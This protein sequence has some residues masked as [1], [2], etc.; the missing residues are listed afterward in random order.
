MI[1][2]KE[3]LVVGYDGSE[4]P[5]GGYVANGQ[6]SPNDFAPAFDTAD[7]DVPRFTGHCR[8]SHGVQALPGDC[9]LC[10]PEVLTTLS[11]C[12]HGGSST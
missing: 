3:G 1:G 11:N 6:V 12:P 10:N 5:E 8:P 4:E 2:W 9:A 7:S